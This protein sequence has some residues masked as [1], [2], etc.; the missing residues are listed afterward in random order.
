[1]P[2]TRRRTAP[3]RRERYGNPEDA[4]LVVA[5]RERLGTSQS[6]LGELLGVTQ[7]SISHIETQERPLTHLMRDR[8]QQL[9]DAAKAMDV[10]DRE[11]SLSCSGQLLSPREFIPHLLKCS[12][13][14][15]R[16]TLL[17]ETMPL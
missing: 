16:S 14:M 3:L 2:V 15:A 6:G 8:I 5:A 7:G 4:A 11:L 1:M 12:R 10:I 13:C 17:R 9:T